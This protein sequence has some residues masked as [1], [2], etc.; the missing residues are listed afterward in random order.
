MCDDKIVKLLG[1]EFEEIKSDSLP[2]A[3][4]LAIY[5]LTYNH[6]EYIR[7]ALEGFV[8]QK[9][10]FEYIAVIIDDASDDGTTE[11]IKEYQRLF[12]NMFHL[13]IAKSN[14][15]AND[16]RIELFKSIKAEYF[17]SKY[18]SFCEGD[19]YWVDD[20]KL[21]KQFDYLE[22]HKDCSLYVHNAIEIDCANNTERVMLEGIDTGILSMENIILQPYGIYPSASMTFRKE[23]FVPD[24]FFAECVVGDWPIQIK[25]AYSGY[26]YYSN[27]CMSKYRYMHKNSW[28]SNIYLDLKKRYIHFSRIVYFLNQFDEYSNYNYSE[29]I[30]RKVKSLFRCVADETD[31]A[32]EAVEILKSGRNEISDKYS[33]FLDECIR[34]FEKK[35]NG[36]YVDERLMRF[37]SCYKKIY[38]MGT[39]NYAGKLRLEL[40]KT[41]I[42]IGGHVVSDNQEKRESFMGLNVFYLKDIKQE[43]NVAVLVGIDTF[44]GDR[45]EIEKSLAENKIE[46][47]YYPFDINLIG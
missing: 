3:P 42:E 2:A 35:K 39:G 15:Y 37:V 14:T 17:K 46:N 41:K 9:T 11:V 34:F 32:E 21:Q 1:V 7:N 43:E 33:L 19:D 24:G 38:I 5:C 30:H 10:N 4:Q 44:N 23:F 27:E 29:V 45:D 12:P 8:N 40:E 20:N 25:A 31:S 13:L 6:I 18:I 22:M 36:K 47:V 16:N 26:V 28:S